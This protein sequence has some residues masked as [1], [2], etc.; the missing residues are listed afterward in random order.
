MSIRI[1]LR[2]ARDRFELVADLELPAQGI[3]ALFG[4]SGCGKTTLLRVIAG[5][6]QAKDVS[7]EV[8]GEHWQGHDTSLPPH[9]RALGYVFQEPSLFSHLN[10]RQNLQYG[11]KRATG[12]ADL[13][14]L[15]PVIELLGI[16]HLLARRPSQLSG[17]EQQRVAIARAVA[18]RPQILLLDEPLAALDDARKQEIIPYLSS[19]QQELSIPMLYVTHS[20]DEV[21]RLADHLVLMEEGRILATGPV[22]ELFARLDLPLAH[23]GRAEAIVE[24][25]IVGHDNDYALSY[26]E[27]PGGCFTLARQDQA[28]GSRVRLQV[29]AK[30]VSLTLQRQ[31]QTSILNIFEARVEEVSQ[32]NASQAMV[33]L[34][35]GDTVLLSRITRKSV[36]SLELQPGASVY[37][38]VKGVAL[39]S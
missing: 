12:S 28:F 26:A 13:N 33:R 16:A 37:A 11:L 14:K 18:L 36:V 38:Q 1:C 17:G 39:L 23:G 8:N 32:E 34:R 3:T 24:G 35:I 9:R 10:V 31:Q 27:F 30:D 29:L 25:V 7:L 22:S 6:E 4:P 15:Q 2:V 5:L 20:R 19:L 21:A